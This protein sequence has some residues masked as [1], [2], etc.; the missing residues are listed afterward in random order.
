MG[1]GWIGALVGGAVAVFFAPVTGGAS[2]LGITG[3]FTMG[4]IGGAGIGKAVNKVISSFGDTPKQDLAK[5]GVNPEKLHEEA[6]KYREKREDFLKEKNKEDLEEIDKLEKKLVSLD[7]TIKNLQTETSKMS[8]D[9]P[10]KSSKL[11]Q[12]ANVEE[13]RDKTQKEMDERKGR[14]NVRNE[15]LEKLFQEAGDPTKYTTAGYNQQANNPRWNSWKNWGMIAAA[16]LIFFVILGFL[17]KLLTNLLK[18][19]N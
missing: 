5:L 1:W 12:L 11:T 13:E 10:N 8:D 18:S 7:N 3:L 19:T 4:A 16:V 6:M 17:R 2:M 15:K 9:D 14:V